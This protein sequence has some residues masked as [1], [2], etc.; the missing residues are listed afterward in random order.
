MVSRAHERVRRTE[1]AGFGFPFGLRLAAASMQLA[2]IV[3]AELHGTASSGTRIVRE[4]SHLCVLAGR[5]EVVC[6]RHAAHDTATRKGGQKKRCPSI[7]VHGQCLVRLSQI[8]LSSS[9][10]ALKISMSGVVC[11]CPSQATSL[12]ATPA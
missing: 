9:R 2:V 7:S 1:A 11:S 10:H 8:H 3:P 12:P 5:R 6:R 4:A